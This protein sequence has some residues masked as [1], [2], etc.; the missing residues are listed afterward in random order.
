MRAVSTQTRLQRLCFFIAIYACIIGQRR[1][2][3]CSSWAVRRHWDK[4]SSDFG[5]YLLPGPQAHRH[6]YLRN[7]WSTVGVS[8]SHS[9]DLQTISW[10]CASI[11]Y[12]RRYRSLPVTASMMMTTFLRSVTDAISVNLRTTMVNANRAYLRTPAV[13]RAICPSPP[14][15]RLHPSYPC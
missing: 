6:R 10:T 8:T 13:H 15:D 5:K 2:R 12:S 1:T 7:M 9:T 14:E 4:S 3:V 11:C